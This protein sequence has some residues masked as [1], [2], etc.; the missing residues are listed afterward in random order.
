M[1]IK[2]LTL[3]CN[4]ALNNDNKFI[5]KEFFSLNNINVALLQETH[6]ANIEA[7]EKIEALYNCKSF[8]SFGANNARGVGILIFNNFESTYSNYMRDIEGRVV[9]I[10]IGSS[11]GN[12]KFVSAYCPND[13]T[14][15]NSFLGNLDPY[16]TGNNPLIIG[17]DWNFVENLKKDKIGGN[18]NNGN[19]GVNIVKKI[20]NAFK[21]KDPFRNKYPNKKVF[22]WSCEA[23]GIKTRLDRFY[24]CQSI[25][26]EV[27]EIDN[28]TSGVSDHYG[29]VLELNNTNYDK[30]KSGKGQWKLN[31]DILNNEQFV[32]DIETEWTKLNNQHVDKDLSWWDGC[33]KTFKEIAIKH[34]QI[35]AKN[36]YKELNQL[37]N[38]LRQ[39]EGLMID[40]D[41]NSLM[42]ELNME[43]SVLKSKIK[44]LF[45]Q[46]YK[47]AYIRSKCEN[48]TNNEQPN[49][50]FLRLEILK[51][52][53]AKI[54]QIK[55][56]NGLFTQSTEENLVEGHDFYGELYREEEVNLNKFSDFLTN[57]PQVPQQIAIECDEDLNSHELHCTAKTFKKNITPGS[58]GLPIEFYLKFWYLI[59]AV[60]TQLVNR[61]YYVNQELSDTQKEGL[62]KLI[63]KDNSKKDLLK[64]YRP[65]SLLNTDYKIIAKSIATRLKKALP[66]IIH[67]DQSFGIP[68][69]SIQDNI[70]LMNALFA[71]ID[72]KNIPSIFLSVDQEKAFDRVSHRYLFDTLKHFGFGDVL[73]N[74]V[75]I[76]Y[77]NIYSRVL[78]NGFTS[79]AIDIGRSVRQGC[80]I[81][82]LLYICVIETLLI[83]IRNDKDIHGIRSPCNFIE[84]L[85]SAF[86]DDTGFFLAGLN[87]VRLVLTK[88]DMFGEV[89]GS[90]VNI[91]KTEGMWLGK[92][93][94]KPDTPLGIKW[95]KSTKSLGIF[96]GHNDIDSLNWV[97]CLD[98]FKTALNLYMIRSNTIM[99]RTTIIN[100]VGYSKIW[101]K[102]MALL[103]PIN[104]CKKPNGQLVDVCKEFD[105]NTL[106]FM[107]GYQIDRQT[108]VKK[109]KK[110]LIAKKTL[111]LPKNNGGTGLI[112]YRKKLKAFRILL[113]YK[114]FEP[115]YK[116]WKDIVRY[117]FCP[118][119]R[120]ISSEVWNNLH[121]HVDSL[122][123]VPLFFKQCILDFKN[124]FERHGS[125]VTEKINTKIIYQNLINEMIYTPASLIRFPVILANRYFLSVFGK[126]NLD[127]Y[128]REFLY[129]FYHCVPYF[130]KYKTDINDLINLNNNNK[131]FLCGISL[132][133]PSHLFNYCKF[134][135]DMR[136]FRNKI[137]KKININN[138][139]ISNE[140]LIYANIP[141]NNNINLMI[142]Y[143]IVLSNY[144]IYRVKM[145]KFYNLNYTPSIS[146]SLYA[147]RHR[148]KFRIICDSKRWSRVQVLETWDPGGQN[149]LFTLDGE[150]NV[151]FSTFQNF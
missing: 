85:I 34:S 7:K 56:N 40:C 46:K 117:W 145:K 96:F 109:I 119:L 23:T 130:K 44:Q 68:G 5:L 25:I 26:S 94:Q 144:V 29:V 90:K 20:K 64:F 133:T 61:I 6:I 123:N 113:V 50:N 71:Y 70:L 43:K 60:F 63:C 115:K 17:G 39:I 142:Q 77:K 38:S 99:G 114:Y 134:G 105:F 111:I 79:E 48:L 131:C 136:K 107:W 9:T 83:K 98:K 110:A 73:I 132:D 67:I 103:L 78:V 16:L 47:A 112:D 66:S 104:I 59:G 81:A 120:S 21:L 27:K 122:E 121:L 138:I 108:K 151:N 82:P 146:E 69:R 53:N 76:L 126:N 129:K 35:R 10:T 57:L 101:Y 147:F 125:S 91:D 74:W 62:I 31:V 88:F 102:A 72:K 150:N 75:K 51:G 11:F 148:L 135:K 89:S 86:A 37:E 141:N 65:I 80:P 32:K 42:E 87:S 13:I 58:D 139:Q 4:G 19:S 118:T 84:H 15:R 95:V 100:Y 140:N 45:E 28:I 3:N 33:K 49:S 149:L 128:L 55:K 93:K 24:T 137:I 22:T 124:Y 52:K 41:D 116:P 18:P 106:A 54:E 127:P 36:Y 1:T 92:H 143:L 2:I 8:W 12:V 14:D 30:F 97:R